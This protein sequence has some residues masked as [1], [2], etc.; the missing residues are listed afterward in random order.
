M[1][2]ITSPQDRAGADGQPPHDDAPV[3]LKPAPPPRPAA[4]RPD[5]KPAGFGWKP[6][7]VLAL[8]VAA[9]AGLFAAG[10][11]PRLSD[12]REVKEDAKPDGPTPVNVVVAKTAPADVDVVLPGNAR[13]DEETQILART[14]GYV[15]K[16]LVDLGD[17]VEK[18]QLLAQI[19]TPEVD[20]ELDQNRAALLQAKASLAQAKATLVRNV[21]DQSVATANYTR[22]KSLNASLSKQE[23]DQF[24]GNSKTADATVVAGEAN[25][26]VA[27][28]NVSAAQANVR[29][30]EDLQSF[31]R[32]K[33]P[34]AG[35]VTARNIDTGSLITAGQTTGP[36]STTSSA[37]TA[38]AGTR[39]MFRVARTDPLR[40]FVN[41]PQ[42]YT[43]FIKVG[44]AGE[45]RA[46]EYPGRAFA[47]TVTRTANALDPAARTLTTEVRVPNPDGKL[48]P[49][50]YVQVKFV[51]HRDRPPVIVPGGCLITRNDGTVVALVGEGDRVSYRKVEVGRDLGDRAEIVSGLAGGERV[52]VNLVEELPDG[53][54]VAPAAM[55]EEP[56]AKK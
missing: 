32:V 53:T 38:A 23:F 40:V 29:R 33:A 19:A 54:V 43:P 49:G 48:L 6:L 46:R 3:E 42:N 31:Q 22:A 9:G 15:E 1:S 8:V 51:T 45:V 26:Q 35:R 24:E 7:L 44:Q 11:L 21:A 25:V 34:F 10:L 47:G 28:A 36:S 30:L 37:T 18:D 20:R 27:E 12:K 55:P 56:A 13:A 41:V 39:E 2:R 14:N 4:R 52:A 50:A 17:R 16:W 5:P